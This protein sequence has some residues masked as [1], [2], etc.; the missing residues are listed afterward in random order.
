MSTSSATESERPLSMEEYQKTSEYKSPCH[1]CNH[2]HS[3]KTDCE[4]CKKLICDYCMYLLPKSIPV[5]Y[6]IKTDPYCYNC[7]HTHPIK[8]NW[9]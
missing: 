4:K 3:V 9:F 2:T 6:P 1:N 7:Y 8:N 5:D